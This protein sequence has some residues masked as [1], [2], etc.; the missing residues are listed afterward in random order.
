MAMLSD[1]LAVLRN[2]ANGYDVLPGTRH[3]RMTAEAWERMKPPA[4]QVF[5]MDGP[6][7]KVALL[8]P[9]SLLHK[10]SAPLAS[11]YLLEPYAGTEIIVERLQGLA[12]FQ[13]YRHRHICR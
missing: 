8:A 1:D 12:A 13:D 9:T 3:Y 7:K 5:P 11:I 10:K 6:R 2:R 4:E